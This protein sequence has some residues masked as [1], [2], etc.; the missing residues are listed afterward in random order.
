[1]TLLGLQIITIIIVAII[2]EKIRSK[3]LNQLFNQLKD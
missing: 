3:K 1:M 2:L